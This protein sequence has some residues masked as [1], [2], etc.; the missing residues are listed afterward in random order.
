MLLTG[1]WLLFGRP[2]LNLTM[3]GVV[4]PLAILLHN[5]R[6][7]GSARSWS[8]VAAVLLVGFDLWVVD[9]TLIEVR[10]PE[11]VFA[12]G[13][14]TAEW[15]AE[16]APG[17]R[18]YSPSYSVPQH[19]A[20][21]YRLALASGVDPL[22][23]R[24]YA[25]YLTRAAGLEPPQQYSVALPPLPEGAAAQ[26]GLQG[27]IPDAE[28]L[29]QLNVRYVVAAFPV[30][31]G[32][33]KLVH[34]SGDTYVY[35]NRVGHDLAQKERPHSIVLANGEVLY[36]Y[37]AWPVYAGWGISCFTLAAL[38]GWIVYP[39]WRARRDG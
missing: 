26:T 30:L 10:S 9:A 25:D 31:D 39:A 18:V 36:Q 16:R 27:V 33:L 12:P 21:R 5:M 6:H 3:F 37:R 2:P 13:Q 1:Y 19:L 7:A 4:T 35:W 34:R 32:R 8:G 14:A 28:M 17:F 22:Q 11:E 24:A 23:L 20:E 29:A 38:I 15:L